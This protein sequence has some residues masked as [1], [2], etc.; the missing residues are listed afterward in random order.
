M[1]VK[2]LCKILSA[3]EA[4]RRLDQTIAALWP[5]VSRKS[6]KRII[7]AGGCYTGNQRCQSPSTLLEP[8][9][10]LKICF[11][12]GLP[13]LE[14]RLDQSAICY[15]DE[16][17]IIVNK[18]SGLPVNL[19]ATGREGSLQLGIRE[20]MSRRGSGHEPAV[21]HRLD[22]PTSGLVLF[23][24]D[25]EAEKHL[26]R[27]F[28]EGNVAKEYLALASPVPFQ[29]DGTIRGRIAR[30]TDRRNQYAVS[31]TRGREAETRFS[32]LAADAAASTAL[33]HIRPLTG[34]P[35]QIRV[36][37]AYIGSPVAGDTL[38]GGQPDPLIFGLHAW[39]ATFPHVDRREPVRAVA[40]VPG[41]W[42]ERFGWIPA[43][44]PPC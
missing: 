34:R 22:Q 3:E 6:A 10:R 33:L 29:A 43:A 19:S 39:Q 13:F 14:F 41:G 21:I 5:D 27:L 44:L 17:F 40:P 38:Y 20:W 9:C 18:P 42:V 12:P 32:R 23:G 2:T 26:Y 25:P 4:G 31:R 7:L 8:G 30:R 11:E 35:H 16:R 36:H 1:S 37:L 24:K 15:E 28:R